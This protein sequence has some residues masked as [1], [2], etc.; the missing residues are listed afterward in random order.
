MMGRMLCQIFVRQS[1][2]QR[3]DML[4]LVTAAVECSA[5]TPEEE[6]KA[7]NTLLLLA[8]LINRQDEVFHG[9]GRRS[10]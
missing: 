4:V 2:H 7:L 3:G 5:A 6:D 1:R 9:F 8:H 10:P